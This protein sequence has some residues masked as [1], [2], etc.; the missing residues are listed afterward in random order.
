MK[1][2]S[3][4]STTSG[5]TDSYDR[6]SKT[7]QE[8]F[9]RLLGSLLQCINL[10]SPD[11]ERPYSIIDYGCS[12][13]ANSVLAMSR[14]IQYVHAHKSI[15]TF[16]AY[17]NDLPSN[18]FNALVGNIE[19]SRDGYQQLPG[20]QVFTQVVPSS[21]FRQVVPDKQVDLG[22]TV[23]AVH[24][25]TRVPDSDYQDAVFLSDANQRE[26]TALLSQAGQDWQSFARARSRELKP[27][28]LL[29]IV[30]LGSVI[31]SV[32]NR[33]VSTAGLFV[34][35]KKV[36]E[37]LV[38]EGHL[39]RE[40]LNAF[41]FP[42]VPR[43]LEEYLKP[44]QEGDLSGD[45]H[46]LHSSMEQGKA[47]D[48]VVYLRDRDAGLYAERYTRFFRSFSK[49]TM[50][51]KL[52]IPGARTMTAGELCDLFYAQFCDAIAASPQEGVF[53]HVMS[54]IVLQRL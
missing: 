17:H 41:V 23:A 39:S 13:G 45:W 42:V 30:G 37:E 53:Q 19:N 12:S 8:D 11:H 29:F 7:Q 27:G 10:T 38:A 5:M 36:L 20:C 6:D 40:A 44:F 14:L 52:F 3:D 2:D 25:L 1:S 26:R 51:D 48:Y 9:L 28:G 22:L 34:V 35:V 15:N 31:D 16:S 47:N 43:T 32:G 4:V 49:A 50:L 54:N 33:E 46:C 21:F 18:D 24:W